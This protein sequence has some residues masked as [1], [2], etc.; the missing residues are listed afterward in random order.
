LKRRGDQLE[1]ARVAEGQAPEKI[2]G[3]TSGGVGG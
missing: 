2:F 3:N 1:G